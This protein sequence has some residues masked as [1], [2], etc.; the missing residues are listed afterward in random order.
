MLCP[1]CSREIP[2]T[3]KTCPF[4]RASLQGIVNINDDRMITERYTGKEI[5]Y[6]KSSKGEN[7][8]LGIVIIGV[9]LLILIG[10]VIAVAIK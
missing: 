2:E 10:I 9:V 8:F 4:C 6:E 1:K 5:Y 7:K 3:I